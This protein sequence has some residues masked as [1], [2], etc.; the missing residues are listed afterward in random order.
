MG[1]VQVQPL[2]LPGQQSHRGPELEEELAREATDFPGGRG[3][4]GRGEEVDGQ[5]GVPGGLL[6]HPGDQFGRIGREGIVGGD[7]PWPR[8][9]LAR[10]VV[11][12]WP[13]SIYSMTRRDC[14]SI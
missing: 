10:T 13:G 11:R 2:H 3:K 9:S 6:G 5:V 12:S 8:E 7:H 4:S 14:T 1:L